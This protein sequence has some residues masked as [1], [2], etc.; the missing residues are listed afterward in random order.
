MAKRYYTVWAVDF[1]GDNRAKV[2]LSRS[3][4][5][6]DNDYDKSLEKAGIAKNGY[7]TDFSDSFVNFVGNCIFFVFVFLAKRTGQSN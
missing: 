7:I 1:E 4:K 2:S 6:K 5:V 3:R